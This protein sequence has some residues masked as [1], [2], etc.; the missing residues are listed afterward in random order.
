MNESI[1]FYV[2]KYMSKSEP[3][4]LD[5][6]ITKGIKKI[7]CEES[8]VSR[9][10]FKICMLIMRGRQCECVFRLCHLNLRDSSRKAVFLNT[11]KPDQRYRLL[12]FDKQAEGFCANIFKRYEK[13]PIPHAKY[14]FA[15]MCLLEFAMLFE[16]HYKKNPQNWL[17]KILIRICMKHTSREKGN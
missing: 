14:D 3:T 11:R 10:L 2:A 17:K 15:N 16:A 13:R 5:D 9:K 8:D 1:A 7:R 4:I 12:K 6:G